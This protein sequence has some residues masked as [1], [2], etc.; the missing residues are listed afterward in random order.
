MRKLIAFALI[1]G[2]AGCATVDG[3]GRDI[4]GAARGVQS[5]F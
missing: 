5:W 4:S 2:L 3:I 1:A